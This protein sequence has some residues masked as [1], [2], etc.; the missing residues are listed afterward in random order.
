MFEITQVLRGRDIFTFS[1]KVFLS[2]A[3]MMYSDKTHTDTNFTSGYD[4]IF[5]PAWI[6][7]KLS[8]ERYIFIPL[9][10]PRHTHKQQVH[11]IHKKSSRT[12]PTAMTAFCSHTITVTGAEARTCGLEQSNRR[13]K[14]VQPLAAKG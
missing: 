7:G 13:R 9:C 2:F 14:K 1:R 8:M 3:Q 10:P 4:L 12:R 6:T 11:H 5:Q